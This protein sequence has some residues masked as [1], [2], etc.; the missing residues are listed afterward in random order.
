MGAGLVKIHIYDNY[1]GGGGNSPASSK[2]IGIIAST[3]FEGVVVQ[4]HSEKRRVRARATGDIV[5]F[6]RQA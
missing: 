4:T 3:I 5:V 6:I 2:T 1:F